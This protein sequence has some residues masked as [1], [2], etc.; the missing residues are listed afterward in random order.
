MRF[1]ENQ[2]GRPEIPSA[3]LSLDVIPRM[4]D[5]Y[6]IAIV[7]FAL[8]FDGY[9]RHPET[10]VTIGQQA[11]VRFTKDGTLPRTLDRLRTCLFAQQRIWRDTG[12]PDDASLRFI[13]ALVERIRYLVGRRT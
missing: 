9:A 3:E 10:A 13:E 12:G 8:T 5:G 1:S 6:T 7:D 4:S 2:F 11:E